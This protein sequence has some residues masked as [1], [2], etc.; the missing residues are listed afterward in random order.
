MPTDD[1]TESVTLASLAGEVA[2]LRLEI[3]VIVE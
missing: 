1:A 2:E 3:G